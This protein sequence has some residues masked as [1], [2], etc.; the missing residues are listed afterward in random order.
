M[1]E[2]E[3]KFVPAPRLVCVELNPGPGRGKNLSEE[4]KWRIIFNWKDLKL[5]PN[6]IAKKLKKDYHT[7]D[8]LI[9]K[10]QETGSVKDR[11]GRG[12]KRKLNASETKKAVRLA[13]KGKCAPEISRQF[14]KEV[15]PRTIQRLLKR[16]GF[17]YGKVKKVEY[18]TKKHKEQRVR[19]AEEM[20]GYNWKTVLFSDE[21]QFELGG[22]STYAWQKVGQ[23][24]I[25]EYVDHAPKLMVWG[26]I[27]SH[28]KSELYFFEGSVDGQ[29]YRTMLQKQLKENK[30]TYSP[31]CPKRLVG[32]WT[33]LQDNA[34]PHTAKE[35]KKLLSSLIG[36]RLIPHPSRS[37][38]LNP[39]ENMWSYLD[40]KV[41]AAK[42]T[43]I[44]SLKR[45]LRKEWK[46]LPW[47][48]IR[49]SVDSMDR[50]LELCRE[51]GGKR[52]PY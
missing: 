30:L 52:L 1:V 9:T 20:D 40:R 3:K 23:R 38:D 31:K 28:V 22:G 7:V 13:K 2:F 18:L 24:P 32:N 16:E 48:E 51:T 11:P 17:F 50:R 41:K 21:K 10:Y 42:I 4:E 46:A 27:G 19:Y 39:I 43:S 37:P 15:N 34:K 47:S 26:A 5:N 6:Q 12:R 33:F 29:A 49:K 25:K 45:V 14:T 35:T 8:D 36:D 44:K